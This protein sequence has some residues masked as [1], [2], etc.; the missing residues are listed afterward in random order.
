RGL[1]IPILSTDRRDRNGVQERRFRENHRNGGLQRRR[2]RVSLP[3]PINI[4]NSTASPPQCPS[5]AS[6]L[7]LV[8][9]TAVTLP[10]PACAAQRSSRTYRTSGSSR[11]ST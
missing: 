10:P 6:P 2:K 5:A 8:P 7:L 1:G 9:G 11:I 3:A 4:Q